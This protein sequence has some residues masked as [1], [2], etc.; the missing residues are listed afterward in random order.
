[1][2]NSDIDAKSTAKALQYQ[3]LLTSI[4]L[5]SNNISDEGAKAKDITGSSTNNPTL[6]SIDL[7]GNNIGMEISEDLATI[8]NALSI[9]SNRNNDSSEPLPQENSPTTPRVR[10][11]K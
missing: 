11:E 8:I 6:T 7:G 4:D 10:P 1:M 5:R 9:F 3:T 2:N